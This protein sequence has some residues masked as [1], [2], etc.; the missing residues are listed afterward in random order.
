MQ[1]LT[2][3]LPALLSP[4]AAVRQQ[5]EASLESL[6]G[7]PDSYLPAL[8]EAAMTC[9]E[10]EVRILLHGARRLLPPSQEESSLAMVF[11]ERCAM[12]QPEQTSKGPALI[13]T[14]TG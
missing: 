14:A 11:H 4:N 13:R 7:Q 2:E 10:P 8:A 6:K 1:V 9:Q 5:A 3:A 12:L